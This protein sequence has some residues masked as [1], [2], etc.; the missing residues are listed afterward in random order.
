MIAPNITAQ[1]QQCVTYQ[2]MHY[3][4]MTGGA[5]Q[6]SGFPSFGRI[7]RRD[8]RMPSYALVKN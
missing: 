6:L 8:S 3:D 4:R 7:C 1:H 5:V 2:L